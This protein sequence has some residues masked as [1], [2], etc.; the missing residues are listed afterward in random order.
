MIDLVIEYREL[1]VRGTVR[2]MQF[3]TL[4]FLIACVLGTVLATLRV[5]P[6][7]IFQRVA[8]A[9]VS[10]FRNLPI[11]L[12]GFVAWFGGNVVGQ[13]FS[14]FWIVPVVLGAYTA[15]YIAEALRSGINSVPV[16]QAEAARAIGLPFAG[17]VGLIVLPQAVRTVIPPI[18][19]IWIANLKNTSV[20]LVIGVSEL[21]R[22]GR[23][24][25]FDTTNYVG[26]FAVVA[27]IYLALVYGSAQVF[28]LVE[29]RVEIV[30]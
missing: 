2:T 12:L 26:A 13:P 11:L 20:F 22:A 25:G 18:A 27:L 3:A 8:A 23:D 5:S 6:V 30:R 9:Y 16:G 4:S 15:A 14:R 28:K 29:R 1:L 24:I 10:F 7:P 21:T 17:V 19:N